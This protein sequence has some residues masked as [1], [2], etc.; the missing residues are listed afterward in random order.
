V[1]IRIQH[2]ENVGAAFD[3]FKEALKLNGF[4]IHSRGDDF[5]EGACSLFGPTKGDQPLR[6]ASP[7]ALTA[8]NR[9]LELRTP[10]DAV[11]K[12]QRLLMAIP[13][14][15][16]VL[17]SVG[18]VVG[19]QG[20]RGFDRDMLVSII[21][22]AVVLCAGL[23]YMNIAIGRLVRIRAIAAVNALARSLAES[24]NGTVS[25]SADDLPSDGS[26]VPLI[27]SGIVFVVGFAIALAILPGRTGQ[28]LD[29]SKRLVLP[30]DK[31]LY[32]AEPGKYTIFYEYRANLD[33]ATHRSPR[34]WNGIGLT[35]RTTGTE[36]VISVEDLDLYA[37]TKYSLPQRA[38]Y[39]IAQF[40]ITSAGEYSLVAAGI[41][42]NQTRVI[43][44]ARFDTSRVLWFA[45]R[46]IIPVMLG[47][48]GFFELLVY[49]YA[50]KLRLAT[51]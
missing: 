4:K 23:A 25:L 20:G 26:R 16:G 49:I 39:S 46:I 34:Q 32:L 47:L 3:A 19:F 22:F 6:T 45:A 31:T 37:N 14:V 24:S 42:S 27:R 51:A 21:A 5:M 18:F 7:I 2:P 11:Q 1:N 41:P 17:M 29:D 33:G 48:H 50:R 13:L 44:V 9:D 10:L 12:V 15:M 40:T 43:S 28:M 38:G 30:R 35:L 36:E 8:R